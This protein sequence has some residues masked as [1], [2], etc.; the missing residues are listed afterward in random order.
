M[1]SLSFSGEISEIHW[2]IAGT[3]ENSKEL[4]VV[5]RE[6]FKEREVSAGM[7]QQMVTST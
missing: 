3:L 2:G 6:E 1:T 5:G 4:K 7:C